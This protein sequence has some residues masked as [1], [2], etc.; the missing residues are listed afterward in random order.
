MHTQLA[1]LEPTEPVDGVFPL[2]L[3]DYLK[4]AE[5]DP[6]LGLLSHD[7]LITLAAESEASKDEIWDEMTQDMLKSSCAFFAQEILQGPAEEPYNGKF[8]LS[9]HHFEWDQLVHDHLRLCVLAP[10]DHG[11]TF[12]FDFAYPIW[13]ALFWPKSKGYIFSESQVQAARILHDIKEEIETNP[14]LQHLIPN[15]KGTRKTYAWGA[16]HIRLSNGSHIYAKSFG[17]KTR[18]AHPNWIV[19]DD[20]V[21]DQSAYSET[22]RVKQIDYFYNAISNMIVPRK[23][24]GQIIVVGTPQHSRDLYG[25]LSENEEYK[26]VRYQAIKEDGTPLWPERYDLEALLAKK[27]EIKS[28]RFTREYQTQPIADDMSLFPKKLFRG[29]PVEQRGVTMGMGIDYWK[30]VGFEGI[31]MGVDLAISAN[32][33]A[34]YTVLFVVGLDSFGNRWILDIIREK[35]MPYQEQLSLINATCRKYAVDLVLIESNQM[36]RI[37][38]DELIRTTD[39]P[40]K[41]FHTGAQKH[42][43]EKG[44]PSLRVLLEN[45]KFRIPRGDAESIAK[46]EEWITE[47]NGF[48]WDEGEVKSVVAHDDIAMA[49]WF[50]DQAVRQGIGFSVAFGDEAAYQESPEEQQEREDRTFEQDLEDLVAGKR[51]VSDDS[52]GGSDFLGRE[53]LE[54]NDLLTYPSPEE[55]LGFARKNY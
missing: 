40:I 13:K 12:F 5:F 42:S 51:G 36:Q 37:F 4:R 45:G 27:R 41:K 30:A 21:G 33:E 38:G 6:E 14:A 49:A 10:R 19:V 17:T 3:G 52:D 31:Y 1:D 26:F 43:L 34:D 32:V 55:V 53:V 29:D 2:G 54:S 35:G 25:D 24:G 28:I 22:I 50:C 47:M 44:V 15:T 11:K 16:T 7:E 8:F 23:Q 48:T 20:G 18:G 46:S 39:L 9:E